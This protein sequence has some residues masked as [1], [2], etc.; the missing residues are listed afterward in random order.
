MKSYCNICSADVKHWSVRGLC[1]D[2]EPK[3]EE[4]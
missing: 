4:E 3:E 2:C 1:E